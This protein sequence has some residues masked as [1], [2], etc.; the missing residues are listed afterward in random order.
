[1]NTPE[2]ARATTRGSDH[3]RAGAFERV[4]SDERGAIM[5]LGI[6]MCT[7]LV[8]ILWYLAGVGDAIIYRERMQE[9]SDAVAFRA[10]VIHARGMNLIVMINL[11]MALILS[12]RVAMKVAQVVCLILAIVFA[13]IP[14]VGE[15]IATALTTAAEFLQD[16]IEATQEPIDETLKAL[17]VVEGAIAYITPPGAVAGSLI[18]GNKYKPTVKENEAAA[19]APGTIVSG[20]PVEDGSP[21]VLCKKAGESVM[22]RIAL[23]GHI[24]PAAAS[25]ASGLFGKVISAGG[26]YF[27][28]IG[29]GGS[30]PCA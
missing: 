22:Q 19:V 5:V 20:L 15:V 10:A 27:C 9:A 26:A 18:V 17:N 30:P 11:L 14:F 3:P 28:D 29:C 1:M 6:F 21:D 4:A 7:C 8:G 23:V 16:A 24:P 12:I 2:R 13:F 25:R